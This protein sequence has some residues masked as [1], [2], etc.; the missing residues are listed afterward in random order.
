M[1]ALKAA[2]RRHPPSGSIH[3]AIGAPNRPRRFTAKRWKQTADELDGSQRAILT[4][5]TK[6]ESFMKMLNVE[7]VH[8]MA[9]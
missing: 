4:T 5:T 3:N 7:A 2:E 1:A 8:P 6:A 9:F